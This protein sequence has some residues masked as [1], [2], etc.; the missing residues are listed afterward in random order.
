M[1][2]FLDIFDL[3]H[4]ILFISSQMMHWFEQCFCS[5]NDSGFSLVGVIS[6]YDFEKLRLDLVLV[7]GSVS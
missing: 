6:S 3:D 7:L 4:H 1:F 5:G 2:Y